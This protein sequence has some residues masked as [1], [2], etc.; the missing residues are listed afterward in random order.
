MAVEV[1]IKS[2][3][4]FKK[5]FALKDILDSGMRYGIMDEA[6]RLDENKV[7]KY[8]VLFEN[9][10]LCRGFEVSLSKGRVDLRLSLP[11][12]RHEIEY[13]Y[14]YIHNLCKKMKTEEFIREGETILVSDI[15]RFIDLDSETSLNALK[16][17]AS[18]IQVGKYEN[19]YLFGA[20]NPISIGKEELKMIDFNLEKL[21]DFMH[22][23]QSLD[24]YYAKANVYRNSENELFGVYTLTEDVPT[25]LPYKG[26]LFTTNRDLK[27]DNWNLALVFDEKMAGTIS[28]D[29]FLGS[30]E[31]NRKY[32]AEH[33]I[34]SLSKEKMKKILEQYKKD[35]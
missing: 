26:Q 11:S 24:V 33:F 5:D 12:S 15:Q 27:V 18:E 13:F 29:D 8:T 4:L 10:H 20:I 17:I 14:R 22:D 7:G 19:M 21:A 9:A 2:K 32:D 3:G 16:M 35:I 31:K 1:T 6:F 30:V 23:H 25:V 28:Y 34:I